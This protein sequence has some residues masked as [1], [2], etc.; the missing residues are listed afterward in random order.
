MNAHDQHEQTLNEL[1]QLLNDVSDSPILFLDETKTSCLMCADDL[2]I[3]S[4]S[5][6]C[7]QK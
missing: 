4:K 2:I 3:L 5:V 6:P 1:P 7:L